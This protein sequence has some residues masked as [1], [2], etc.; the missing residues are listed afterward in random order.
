M[1]LISR[2]QQ[3]AHC[4]A[5]NNVWIETMQ[6]A[7]LVE[8]HGTVVETTAHV[9]CS[10]IVSPSFTTTDVA[11]ALKQQN[12][13]FH[14]IVGFTAYDI[15]DGHHPKVYPIS[16]NDVMELTSSQHQ[17]P[18]FIPLDEIVQLL[19]HKCRKYNSSTNTEL[20]I[21]CCRSDVCSYNDAAVKKLGSKVPSADGAAA[22]N[23]CRDVRIQQ[24]NIHLHVEINEYV[25][26]RFL[27]DHRAALQA[28]GVCAPV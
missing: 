17:C 3:L 19:D 8:E 11:N 6:I 2:C 22:G 9:E 15:W 25:F 4:L 10:H 20:V 18:H 26:E 28:R 16:M 14:N 21:G 13:G 27:H 5:A 1:D 23:Q 12:I 24:D 7:T